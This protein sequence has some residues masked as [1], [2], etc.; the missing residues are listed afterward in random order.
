ME[1]R[2]NNE[3]ERMGA[4]DIIENILRSESIWFSR[5]NPSVNSVVYDN[6]P[7]SIIDIAQSSQDWQLIDAIGRRVTLEKYVIEEAPE[8]FRN[9]Q[10]KMSAAIEIQTKLK[11]IITV[12]I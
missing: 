4:Q 7:Q 12:E 6:V 1:L 10:D 3:Y 9:A 8:I 5:K 11:D 2:F